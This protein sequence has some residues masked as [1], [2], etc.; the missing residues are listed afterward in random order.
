MHIVPQVREVT[1]ELVKDTSIDEMARLPDLNVDHINL[2]VHHAYGQ[3]N[4][5][6]A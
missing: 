5:P 1:N 6:G 2:R 3:D 4:F